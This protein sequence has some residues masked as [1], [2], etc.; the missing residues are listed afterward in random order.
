MVA[1]HTRLGEGTQRARALVGAVRDGL[2]GRKVN[3]VIFRDLN[4]VEV[5]KNN[6]HYYVVVGLT[7][8]YY[9]HK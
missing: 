7:F 6:S 8:E 5:G 9:E 1:I 4:D 3:G 2:Q